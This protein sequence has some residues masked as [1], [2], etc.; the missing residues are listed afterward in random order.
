[1]IILRPALPWRRGSSSPR[2]LTR[3]GQQRKLRRVVPVRL[4][5]QNFL[6]YGEDV[7][8]L[9]LGRVTMACLS[10]AN[11]H[12]K[13]ALLDAVTWALWGEG[14]K[15]GGQSKPHAGLLRAGCDMMFVE[16]DFDHE[17]HRYRVRRS[18]RA[19]TSGGRVELDLFG[20]D[21]AESVWHPLTLDNVNATERR[22][23]N[24]LR[25]DYDTFQN[26]A[27]L[28]QGRADSF[29]RQQPSQRK[30]L[31]AD[32]LGLERYERLRQLARE[33]GRTLERRLATAAGEREALERD[34]ADA[35]TV[36]ERL[37]QVQSDVTAGQAAQ[38]AL[39][40]ELE[41]LRKAVAADTARRARQ[42]DLAA[43]QR[44][45]LADLADLRADHERQVQVRD[46]LSALI[47]QKAALSQ[48][49][50][51]LD[52]LERQRRD[53]EA[54]LAA[55]RK[56]ESEVVRLES[57]LRSLQREAESE[58]RKLAGQVDQLRAKLAQAKPVLGRRERIR[59]MVA[60]EQQ[61]R[62]QL[63]VAE[64]NEQRYHALSR[65]IETVSQQVERAR[66]ELE[67]QQRQA[68]ELAKA[69]RLA[70][71]RE[72]DLAVKLA[73]VTE[74]LAA[75]EAAADELAAA[76]QR[77]SELNAEFATMKAR[78]TAIR[79]R[80]AELNQHQAML[81]DDS[82][83]CPVCHSKLSAGQLAQVRVD[84][85]EMRSALE[86]E[87]EDL[88]VAG[89]KLRA[90]KDDQAARSEALRKAAAAQGA[91]HRELAGLEKE[92]A[93]A[94]AAALE[95]ERQANRS[96]DLKAALAA[97][98]YGGDDAARLRRLR[99]ERDALVY[100]P[101]QLA[102]LRRAL[103]NSQEVAREK[104]ALEQA[105]RD[106]AQVK[107]ELPPLESE[108]AE[109]DRRLAENA[110]GQAEAA[111]LERAREALEPLTVTEHDLAVVDVERRA[112]ADAPRQLQR[113]EDA[114]ARLPD[115]LQRLTELTGRIAEREQTVKALE[116]ERGELTAELLDRD[117]AEPHLRA[118][119][120][121]ADAG[122]DRL[123]TLRE[124]L[125]RLQAAAE[126]QRRQAAELAELEQKQTELSRSRLVM[127]DLEAAFGRDGI[128]ALI[129]ENVVPE[130]ERHA[131]ELLDRLAG[132]RMSLAI[133]LQKPLQGG[134]DRDTLELEISD[135]LGTRSYENYSGGE[136]FRVDFALRLALSRLLAGRA[137]ARLRT[138]II[139]EGFGT[140]DDDGIEQL[141]E[142][143]HA[144][145]D[146]FDLLLVVTHLASLKERFATRIEVQKEP[147]TGSRYEVV[148]LGEGA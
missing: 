3:R 72:P 102:A 101:D 119:E 83:Q 45:T 69:A 29:T 93:A 27:Y 142:A 122:R 125:G 62:E 90:E 98:E 66:A 63:E 80:Q 8:P 59:Q 124:E 113:V 91:L 13:S 144:V 28:R 50:A 53:C 97:G 37:D 51:R 134:G 94:K 139:D 87:A 44:R 1:M 68:A 34:L 70:A 85:A 132:G 31:L 73:K 99:T 129:I 133:R 11:G 52:E 75:A 82:G 30:Q 43:Q 117:E 76:E 123:A 65:E 79:D 96:A 116:A 67:A 109:L 138:L 24:L 61:R 64:Q 108:L 56:L 89:R 58:R 10:G 114:E 2:G 112:L 57:E 26:S 103:S 23:V 20:W 22:I 120:A 39:I 21:E 130:I 111:A 141:V 60:A 128:P 36:V 19:R 7:P 131:N 143:L 71:D 95:H 81:D 110:I 104:L 118:L 115:E 38:Q 4:Q 54:S 136:A 78:N 147:G 86:E 35:E 100:E 18:Y 5:L 17:G 146:E 16:L 121:Q 84:Y 14:R 15:A 126:R 105:E 12:G 88:K 42:A 127:S 46:T 148:G 9:D 49:V 55:R 74:Q 145:R 137:G 107:Q 135:E 47:E 40:A 32:M 48:A 140:Q 106:E 92:L 6:S 77:A 25:M 33:R 41:A